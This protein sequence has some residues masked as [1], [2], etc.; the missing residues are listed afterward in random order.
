MTLAVL[1]TLIWIV[2]GLEL[3]AAEVYAIRL[4]RRARKAGLDPARF[5]LSWH[6][7]WLRSRTITRGPVFALTLWA[8]YHFWFEPPSM[9]PAVADDWLLVA[10]ATLTGA[11]LIRPRTR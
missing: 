6:I 8:M 9:I 3:L 10:V 4:K 11:V 1:F 7:W 2:I 5:T